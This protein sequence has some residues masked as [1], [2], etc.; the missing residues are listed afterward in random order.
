MNP[1]HARP[2]GMSAYKD[3][4]N[5][6]ASASDHRLASAAEVLGGRNGVVMFD[7]VLA[8]RPTQ[9][10]LICEVIDPAPSAH[11]CATEYG[12]AGG[13][14]HARFGSIQTEQVAAGS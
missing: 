1:A 11:R 13:K 2:T 6:D 10:E 9:A 12:S 8:L 5:I 4:L 14:C 3:A 7:G